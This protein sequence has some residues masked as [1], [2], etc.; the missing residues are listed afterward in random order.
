MAQIEEVP[1]EDDPDY[2]RD[3]PLHMYTNYKHMQAQSQ[4]S[5]NPKVIL[6]PQRTQEPTPTPVKTKELSNIESNASSDSRSRRRFRFSSTVGAASS[7]GA[8]KASARL[9]RRSSA[10]WSCLGVVRRRFEKHM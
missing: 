7:A 1:D 4:D 3:L 2:N 6:K 5:Q 10:I 8:T 9:A